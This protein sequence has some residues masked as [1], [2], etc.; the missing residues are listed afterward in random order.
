MPHNYSDSNFSP[1]HK[2]HSIMRTTA[3]LEMIAPWPTE[4]ILKA[5]GELTGQLKEFPIFNIQQGFTLNMGSHP[6]AQ[7]VVPCNTIAGFTFAQADTN[8]VPIKT[9]QLNQNVIFSTT[10]NYRRW[11]QEL[12]DF[13]QHIMSVAAFM[14]EGISTVAIGLEYID[15]FCINEEAT[16]RLLPLHTILQSDSPY[17]SGNILKRNDFWHSHHGFFDDT[18]NDIDRLLNNININLSDQNGIKLDIICNHRLILGTQIPSNEICDDSLGIHL[19]TLHTAHKKYIGAIL[20]E[21][22]KQLIALSC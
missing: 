13:K 5:G 8:G 17:F 11:E 21:S 19:T 9:I 22:A 4:V 1:L 7:P 3:A 18:Q 20:T 10:D 2:E 14:P 15:R 6:Q 12:D 16:E